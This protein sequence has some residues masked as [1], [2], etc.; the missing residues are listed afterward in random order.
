MDVRD[1]TTPVY[2][3]LTIPK[4]F[5]AY[6]FGTAAWLSI[7]A[8]PLLVAPKLITTMLSSET[9]SITGEPCR[10]MAK[11]GCFNPN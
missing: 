3:T 6:T 8:L 1:G 11:G 2:P 5:Y 9:H 10:L 4:V 7:Q